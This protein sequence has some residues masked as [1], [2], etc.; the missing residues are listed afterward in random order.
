MYVCGDMFCVCTLVGHVCRILYNDTHDYTYTLL[1]IHH[2]IHIT[3]Y[4]H[5]CIG[6]GV[7]MIVPNSIMPISS[8]GNGHSHLNIHN[9][10]RAGLHTFIANHNA[11]MPPATSLPRTQHTRSSLHQIPVPSVLGKPWGN[12][13]VWLG[14]TLHLC[15]IYRYATWLQCIQLW[16]Y[17]QNESLV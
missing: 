1:H 7:G 16:Q 3:M 15:G 8:L 12:A 13:P 6:T 10:Y 4:T 9:K 14:I 2:C 17:V 5:P 11:F